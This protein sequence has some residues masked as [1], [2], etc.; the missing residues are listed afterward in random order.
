MTRSR[1]SSAVLLAL[2]MAAS[3]LAAG[4]LT[5]A[6]QNDEFQPRAVLPMVAADSATGVPV[7]LAVYFFLEGT[8]TGGNGPFLVPVHREV[9]PTTGVA[10]AALEQLLAGPTNDESTSVPAISSTVPAGTEL[11]GITISNSVATVDLSEEFESGGG[12][13]SVLGRLA[14]LVFTLTQFPTVDSVVLEIE[15][16]VVEEF[17][18]E[19]VVIDGP[20]TREDFLDFAPS[21]LVETPHY[22]GPAGNPLRVTGIANVFEAT[23]M[24]A[25]VDNDGLILSEEV[26]TASCGT[27]CWGTFDVTVP[28][29]VDAPQLG[30]VI[31]WFNSAQDGSQRDIREY[32]VWLTPAD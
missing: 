1:A 15:G 10:R 23:F 26:V 14:Q 4:S 25:L 11:L 18:S 30:A 3:L 13:A 12:S 20:L 24:L 29:T 32:P 9:P 22:G 21:I 2:V 5:R 19:G 27:G 17:S 8:A 7:E 31:V 16:E 28:Y 6:Q